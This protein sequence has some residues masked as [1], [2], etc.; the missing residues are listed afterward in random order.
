MRAELIIAGPPAMAVCAAADH[1]VIIERTSIDHDPLYG[2]VT[3][4][5]G[6][7]APAAL[8]AWYVEADTEPGALLEFTDL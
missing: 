5:R 2:P 4:I 1:G 3:V 7:V 8:A 6:S